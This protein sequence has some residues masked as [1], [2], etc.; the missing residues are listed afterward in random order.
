MSDDLETKLR[1]ALRPVDTD[2][3]LAQRV[4]DALNDE[5]ASAAHRSVRSRAPRWHIPVALAASIAALA[6][7]GVQWRHHQY[8]EEGLRAREELLEALRV[9]SS[10]LDLAYRIVNSDAQPDSDNGG[11]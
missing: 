9:T 3:D 7:V 4:L 11:A 5:D 1:R 6:I 10:K 2:V 8:E